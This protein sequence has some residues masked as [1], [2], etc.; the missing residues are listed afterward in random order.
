MTISNFTDD[1]TG[2]LPAG[3]TTRPARM[4]D[5]YETVAM[6]NDSALAQGI[7]ETLSPDTVRLEW[8]N[9]LLNMDA[10]TRVIL[11]Q[12]EDIVA[13]MELWDDHPERARSWGRVHP[14]YQ[15]QGLG[16]YLLRW[17]EAKARSNI[18]KCPPDVR[19]ALYTLCRKDDTAAKALFQN[20]DMQ[21][22]RY[23]YTM[24]IELDAAP[25][26]PPLPEGISVRAYRH[27]DDLTDTVLAVVDSFRDHW[28]FI[29]PNMEQELAE[30]RHTMDTD[31]LFDPDTWLLAVDDATGELAGVALNR[32]EAW[33][34]PTA[35]HVGTLGVRRDYRKRGLG[36]ALLLHSFK[37]LYEKGKPTITLGVDASS[38]TGATRLYERAGM[39]VD[40]VQ[41]TYEKELRP[42]KKIM[43]EALD[44]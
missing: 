5:L 42:G 20:A 16:T 11:N 7:P 28:G 44:E 3:F 38:L 29:E 27:P 21:P 35:G 10:N 14:A 32:L 30:W 13:Y 8:E 36:Y 22:V 4:S 25:E 12:D 40:S 26:P 37:L 34:N 9:P 1:K 18:P 39:H 19:V 24:K 23:F 6:L 41:T 17:A 2:T 43:T 33:D 31:P 15:R